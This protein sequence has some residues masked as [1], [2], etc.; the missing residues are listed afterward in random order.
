ME[1]SA[2][3]DVAPGKWVQDGKWMTDAKAEWM[4]RFDLERVNGKWLINKVS[5]SD[6]QPQFLKQCVG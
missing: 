6:S 3:F 5:R 1:D 4:D 2:S